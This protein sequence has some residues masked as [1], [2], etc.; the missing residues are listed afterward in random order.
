MNVVS[1]RRICRLV[2]GINI[3]ELVQVLP[4]FIYFL[5]EEKLYKPLNLICTSETV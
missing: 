5:E 1:I 2:Y 4:D 3:L